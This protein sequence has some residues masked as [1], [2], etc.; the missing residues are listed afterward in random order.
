MEVPTPN[1]LQYVWVFSVGSAVGNGKEKMSMEDHIFWDVMS[2]VQEKFTH[3]S[4]KQW[5]CTSLNGVV[6]QK[7]GLCDHI[8]VPLITLH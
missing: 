7:T 4:E 6:N 1:T 3:I 8:R 2:L 5:T